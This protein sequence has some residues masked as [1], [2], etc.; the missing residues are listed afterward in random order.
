VASQE[1]GLLL[2]AG[3]HRRIEDGFGRGKAAVRAGAN[4]WIEIGKAA[5][6]LEQVG[7]LPS[8]RRARLRASQQIVRPVLLQAVLTEAEEVFLG[9]LVPL[10]V[11][12]HIE[13]GASDT[14]E[15][16]GRGGSPV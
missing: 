4:R 12:E 9:I 15:V 3:N 13:G 2:V 16:D 6:N 1:I 8:R 14:V 5:L 7:D 10:R 11:Q